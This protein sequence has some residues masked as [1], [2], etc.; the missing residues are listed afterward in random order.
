MKLA[1]L[2]GI[3][4]LVL[5]ACGGSDEAKDARCADAADAVKETRAYAKDLQ[6]QQPDISAADFYTDLASSKVNTLAMGLV[7]LEQQS[8]QLISDNSGCF[9]VV[10][11][12][13]ARR[14]L[15]RIDPALNEA[16]RLLASD[17]S[18]EG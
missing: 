17:P 8:F 15:K 3:T 2:G 9:D 7:D 4:L 14:V 5:A 18:G 12:A 1:C 16:T 11:V 6:E 13:E 10:Q